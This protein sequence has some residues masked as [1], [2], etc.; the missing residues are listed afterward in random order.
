M[1]RQI[2]LGI[3]WAVTAM[4][5]GG[6]QSASAQQSSSTNYQ[7]NEAFFGSGGELQACS[8]SYCSKQSAGELTVGNSKSGNYQ[9]WAGFNTNREPSLVM[10]VETP[11]VDLGVLD[12]GVARMGFAKFTVMSYLASGYVVQTWGGTP[13]IT[14]H[15]LTPMAPGGTSAMGTEQFGMNL[16]ANTSP[17]T[18]GAGPEQAPDFPTDPFGFGQV[19]P[20]Y[21]T[22]NQYHYTNGEIIARSLKSSGTTRYTIS[23]LANMSPITPAGTYTMDHVLVA[24]STF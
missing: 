4:C 20:S 11:S 1:R 21:G 6:V 14:T 13:K 22:P 17:Q 23:Y 5:V 7:I 19:E 8:G 12:T 3:V 15:S 18:I 10:I 16:V 24:T 2:V 9:I